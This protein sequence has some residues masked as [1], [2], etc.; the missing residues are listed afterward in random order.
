VRTGKR[1]ELNNQI[2]FDME[3]GTLFMT[4]P[5]GRRLVYPEACLVPGK[6]EDTSAL[7]FKDNAKG[8]WTNVEVWYGTIVE[9][10]VQ[11]TA[12]DLL[13]AAMLRLESA[14]YTIVLTVH[15]E[16]V[17]EVPE[18]FGSVEEFQRLMV[19]L[20]E[21]AEGLPTAAK[22]W[23]RKRYAKSKNKPKPIVPTVPLAV[24]TVPAEPVDSFDA[25]EPE[26]ADDEIATTVS[27]FDL[28][29]EAPVG[30]KVCCPFHDDSKPSLQIY[31]DHYHCFVCNAHGGPIDWLMQ[32]ESMSREDAVHLLDNWDGPV[33]SIVPKD[34]ERNH[35]FAL[36]LWNEARPIAGTLAARYLTET[37]GIDLAALPANIDSV[38]GFHPRCP[39]GPGMRHPCLV[40]LLRD[41]TTDAITG[42]HRIALTPDAKK[43]ERRMLG[44][45]GAVKLW[46]AGPQ[47]VV[48]EGIETTLAGALHFTHDD[49][50]LRPAWSLVSNDALGRLPV[51]D[52]VERLII[53]VDNDPSGLQA[54]RSAAARWTGAGRTVVELT[55]DQE[56]ADFNDLIMLEKVQ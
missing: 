20:P 8:G 53:L 47:L 38:L 21:W 33:V 3:D 18:E 42:I 41:I 26:E 4:L 50:P 35:D 30:G 43:I 28:V 14:G 5:S 1:T 25:N 37:R 48:G 40:A 6:F 52:G 22:V 19:E 56:G 10:V 13:A 24:P 12:R 49:A 31:P 23:T 44:K 17:A 34:P 55:P 45:T 54:A 29:G 16:I 46:P 32:V 39:F 2:F 27:L 11:A 51:V 36:T 9:N 15:D 7:R